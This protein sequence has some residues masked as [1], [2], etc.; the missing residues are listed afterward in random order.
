[1]PRCPVCR[2]FCRLQDCLSK[3]MKLAQK[4]K[5]DCKHKQYCDKCGRYMANHE[6]CKGLQCRVC[7]AYINTFLM[8]TSVTCL[9]TL[10]PTPQTSRFC[11]TLGACRRQVSTN[12]I[13]SMPYR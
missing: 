12:Q 8:V 9:K 2:A 13:T 5:K 6:V 1:M 4:G 3:H 10:H 11:M 7:Y